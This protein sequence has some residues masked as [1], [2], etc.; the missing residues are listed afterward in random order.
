LLGITDRHSIGELY[1]H[2]GRHGHITLV[3]AFKQ[4]IP[5]SERRL[6]QY[7]VACFFSLADID[8]Q[9]TLLADIRRITQFYT[10][11][12]DGMLT[13][14]SDYLTEVSSIPVC[15]DRPEQ[16]LLDTLEELL[17]GVIKDLTLA[18]PEYL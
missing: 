5:Y 13:I 1:Y 4:L 6:D 8:R 3:P 10:F 17:R 16:E 7:A 2:L 11:H 9:A 14:K 12:F 18:P 15:P